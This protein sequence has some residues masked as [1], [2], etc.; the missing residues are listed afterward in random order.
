MRIHYQVV[1]VTSL[2][3]L[4]LGLPTTNRDH[5]EH[6]ADA[7]SRAT[8]RKIHVADDRG[9]VVYSTKWNHNA[10][11]GIVDLVTGVA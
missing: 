10:V 9:E 6:C 3:V 7:A 2:V 1:M 4:K 11:P 5:A 8:G